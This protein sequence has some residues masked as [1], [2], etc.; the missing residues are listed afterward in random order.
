MAGGIPGARSPA[1]RQAQV[2]QVWYSL[3]SQALCRRLASKVWLKYLFAVH[4]FLVSFSALPA[5]CSL[6]Y[7]V[8]LLLT[9]ELSIFH[10]PFSAMSP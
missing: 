6:G 5:T 10:R 7:L 3:R 4:C 1:R 9:V 2:A 8:W